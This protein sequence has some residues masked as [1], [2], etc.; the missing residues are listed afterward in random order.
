MQPLFHY[1]LQSDTKADIHKPGSKSNQH[2]ILTPSSLQYFISSLASATVGL[3]NQD[4]GF[5]RRLN[6]NSSLHNPKAIEGKSCK[7]FN[8]NI[9]TNSRWFIYFNIT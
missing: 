4:V 2:D 6:N 1:R 9:D 8:R 3:G 5:V 7:T